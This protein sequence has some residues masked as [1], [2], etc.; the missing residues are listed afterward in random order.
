MK[1]TIVI[2]CRSRLHS[3]HYFWCP[4]ST[5]TFVT[6]ALCAQI[7]VHRCCPTFLNLCPLR[8]NFSRVCNIHYTKNSLE[9]R[10]TRLHTIPSPTWPN[11]LSP[12]NTL[13][14]MLN[15]IHLRKN[16]SSREPAVQWSKKVWLSWS[17]HCHSEIQRID[18]Q[19]TACVLWASRLRKKP[20]KGKKSWHCG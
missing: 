4:K 2:G 12:H 17:C 1:R 15:Q 14:R 11:S 10:A 6:H 16:T 7:F 19:Y 5:W 20:R 18:Y 9:G 8:L 3:N 13:C